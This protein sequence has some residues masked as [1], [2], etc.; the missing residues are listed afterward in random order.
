MFADD[1][2]SYNLQIT[3]FRWLNLSYYANV[4]IIVLILGF[5]SKHCWTY[6]GLRPSCDA[7]STMA[8]TLGL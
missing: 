1:Q 8:T 7:E 4:S 6:R 5:S 3:V 2:H